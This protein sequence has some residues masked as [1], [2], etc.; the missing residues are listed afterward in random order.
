MIK[1]LGQSNCR[2]HCSST[3]YS[4]KNRLF[5]G[6]SFHHRLCY[7][8]RY[9]NSSVD[10]IFIK[11]LW[12]IFFRPSSNTWNL[13]FFIRLYSNNL[14]LRIFLFQ[15]TACSHNCTCCPHRWDKMGDCSLSISINLWASRLVVCIIIIWIWK[16]IQHLVPTFGDFV[17][18]VISWSLDSFIGWRQNYFCSIS[19]H[20]LNSLFCRVLGHD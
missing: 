10:S 3:T 4:C 17:L 2:W 9:V 14:N 20:G 8:L 1:W 5:I 15:V 7:L 16:L 13:S 11:N 18:S 19:L 6:Q 12:K